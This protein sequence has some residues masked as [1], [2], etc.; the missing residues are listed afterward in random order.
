MRT[1]DQ[2][3][4]QLIEDLIGCGV[5]LT[6]D[7]AKEYSRLDDALTNAYDS[8]TGTAWFLEDE[9]QEAA[10]ELSREVEQSAEGLYVD[11]DDG[12]TIVRPHDDCPLLN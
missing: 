11:H 1:A 6:D 10:E 4:M 8:Y 7:Q 2:S 3:N 12:Y 9:D 5:K